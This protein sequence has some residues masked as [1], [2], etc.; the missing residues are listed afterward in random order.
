MPIGLH[1]AWNFGQWALGLKGEPGLWKATVEEGL[2]GP[3]EL[4]GTI[5]YLAVMASAT[6]AFWLWHRGM[7]RAPNVEDHAKVD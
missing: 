1:A 2:D 6:L 4:S 7:K 3:A 5:S